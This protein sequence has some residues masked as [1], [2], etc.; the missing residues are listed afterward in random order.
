MYEELGSDVDDQFSD[1]EVV[2]NR[3]LTKRQRAK[4]NNEGS[5][6]FLELPMGKKTGDKA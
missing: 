3:P 4:L 5:E 2:T 1:T 6:Q